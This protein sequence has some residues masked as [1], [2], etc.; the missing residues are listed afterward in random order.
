MDF[1]IGSTIGAYACL[2]G[3]L[4]IFIVPIFLMIGY[5]S[6]KRLGVSKKALDE[7]RDILNSGGVMAP[8]TILSA[9]RIEGSKTDHTVD[10]EVEVQPEDR[11]PFRA[12]YR[13]VI[14]QRGYT[15]VGSELIGYAGRKIWVV[16]DP[17]NLSR[18]AFHHDDSQHEEFMLD[19]RREEFN[20]LTAGNEDLKKRGEQAE[21]VITRVGD[22]NLPYPLKQSRAVHICFD[23]TPKTGAV[24][25]AEGDFLIG[26]AAVQKYSVGKKFYVRFD[27]QNP[28]WAVLDTE[29]NKSL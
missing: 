22:L 1:P 14:S 3:I 21:A 28:K 9:R 23:V 4:L 19:R 27:P 26:D 29:R 5:F 13:T 18:V 25:Q 7:R 11:S 10:F 16:Y 24:F 2:A 12:G 15:A 6:M 17:N 20:K 8:A